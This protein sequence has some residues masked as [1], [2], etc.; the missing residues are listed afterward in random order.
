MDLSVFFEAADE[1][2][3]DLLSSLHP[4]KLGKH[5]QVYLQHFPAWEHAE[6]VLIG[7]NEHRG[8]SLDMHDAADKIRKQLYA[9]SLPV[10]EVKVVDLGNLKPR[11]S[12]QTYYGML[13]YVLQKLISAG[14][15]VIII[16][17]SQ[18]IS[19][20]QYFAYEELGKEIEYVQIDSR[21]DLLDSDIV[22]NNESFNHKIFIHQPNYLFNFTNLGYQS[23]F[24]SPTQRE[25]LKEMHFSAIRYGHLHQQIQEAEPCLRTADMVSFD[26]SAIRH[27]DSPA[28]SYASPG[29]FD[30]MEACRLARYAGLGYRTSSFSLNEYVPKRDIH[31]QTAMLAAMMVWY[32]LEGHYHRRDDHPREDRANLRKYT[33]RL[34]AGVEAIHFFQ[35][36]TSGRWWMEVPFQDSLGARFPKTRLVP[37]S[38]RDYQFAKTDDIPER[39]WMT[40]HKLKG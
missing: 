7:S 31:E 16:G 9:M 22:L 17:G 39:W 8:S 23:Y 14:K 35:H 18:D 36:P 40:Y 25:T 2:L 11:E 1:S 21:F 10:Q 5:I 20:G 34:H 38:E 24:V 4:D 27:V 29:G 37:C 32:F 13:A 12:Q 28:G 33:V 26:L 15:R 30:S 6:I 19:L 3:E